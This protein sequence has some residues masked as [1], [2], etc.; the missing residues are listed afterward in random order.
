MVGVSRINIIP[1]PGAKRGARVA[2]ERRVRVREICKYENEAKQVQERSHV[3]Q[4]RPN[5]RIFTPQSENRHAAQMIFF[6]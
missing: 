6:R 4:Q 1:S 3:S 2:R 5:F